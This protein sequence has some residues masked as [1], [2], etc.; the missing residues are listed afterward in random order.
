MARPF[1]LETEE[2]CVHHHVAIYYE[3]Y[4]KDPDI[5]FKPSEHIALADSINARYLKSLYRNLE[6]DYELY[7]GAFIEC[8]DFLTK[9]YSKKLENAASSDRKKQFLNK[10][11]R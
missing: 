10:L 3:E 8:I 1:N 2:E 11:K 9:I 6:F 4:A 5:R 7:A